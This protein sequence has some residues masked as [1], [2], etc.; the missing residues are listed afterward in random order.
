MKWFILL[1]MIYL[2][3]DEIV[4][5]DRQNNSQ[6]WYITND[7]VMGGLSKS[8]V[9]LNNN[10]AVVFSGSV[11]TKNN[12]GF[13]M[14]RFPVNVKL[15]NNS[16]LKLKLKVKG[17]GKQYQLR[18]KS[19]KYQRFWYV[20]SFKTSNKVEEIELKLS[21]FY[22]SYR[23]YKLNLLNFN[24]DKIHEVAVLIGNKKE[25]KFSLEIE[26]ITIK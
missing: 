23:G 22:P 11:S 21:D 17:D 7:D 16:K 2:L 18:I 26:K 25:E 14:T 15:K 13:A 5:F 9:Y 3:T 6:N 24:E 19:K 1:S 12:G 8:K 4:I 10:G 20:Q